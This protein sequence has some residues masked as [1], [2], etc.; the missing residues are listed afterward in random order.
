MQKDIFRYTP[1]ILWGQFGVLL[2]STQHIGIFGGSFDPV[3]SGHVRVAKEILAADN[4][5]RLLII[6]ART[7]PLKPNGANTGS[8]DRLAM[9]QLAFEATPQVE[10]DT[11]ELNREGL[12][13]TY[14][15][16]EQLKAKYSDTK[17]TLYLGTDA[18]SLLP[19][20]AKINYVLEMADIRVIMRPG[21]E[22]PDIAEIQR[23]LGG[24]ISA[25]ELQDGIQISSTELR[26]RIS[27]GADLTGYLPNNVTAHIKKHGLYGA[28]EGGA[29]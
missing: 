6:P 15:T 27:T 24:S 3:H 16:L 13:Y 19:K 8:T 17:F 29:S 20:W 22:C 4:L 14:Q 10:I 1:L 2:S 23:E 11:T 12:S 9:L 18:T 5:T 7:Q 28:S 26:A 25:F 21:V